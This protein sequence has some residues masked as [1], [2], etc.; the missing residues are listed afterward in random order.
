MP[1]LLGFEGFVGFH[2]EKDG[3]NTPD[4]GERRK[5]DIEVSLKE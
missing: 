2:S 1:C 3:E 5:N 4:Q